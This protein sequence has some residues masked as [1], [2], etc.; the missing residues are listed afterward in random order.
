LH[1]VLV[2][3][4]HDFGVEE[5]VWVD[6]IDGWQFDSVEVG[7]VIDGSGQSIDEH[8]FVNVETNVQKM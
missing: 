2:S 1:F 7:A 4:L 8:A 5:V 6:F 3:L